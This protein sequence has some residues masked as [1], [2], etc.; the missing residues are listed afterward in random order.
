VAVASARPHANH[1]HIAPDTA[2]PA[3]HKFFYRPDTIPDA[4]PT[5]SKALKAIHI[6]TNGTAMLH[7]TVLTEYRH[8]LLQQQSHRK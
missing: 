8:Q 1:L 3:L 4:Q 7:C 2:T 6:I 5:A